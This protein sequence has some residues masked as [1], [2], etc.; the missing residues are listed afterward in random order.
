MYKFGERLLLNKRALLF[1]SLIV[2]ASWGVA[3]CGRNR[4][5][6]AATSL[7]A[8]TIEPT[9][10]ASE[11][12][13]PGARIETDFLGLVGSWAECDHPA[14]AEMACTSSDG[15][16]R[17]DVDLSASTYG[18]LRVIWS[19]GVAPMLTGS[20]TLYLH[21][22]RSGEVKPNL[23]L[24][25]SDGDRISVNLAANGLRDGWSDIFLPLGEFKDSRG[26]SARFC[27]R[28]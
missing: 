4:N 26:Q 6:S 11:A 17:M 19:D 13:I 5:Q 8:A 18:R 28:E 21:A 24:V 14:E 22:K 3:A 23:Y 1:V 15:L 16:L 9:D 7:P 2:L 10:S 25:E 27:S 20:E 12:E